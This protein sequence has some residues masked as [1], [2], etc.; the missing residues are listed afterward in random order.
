[1]CGGQSESSSNQ[2]HEQLMEEMKDLL[3]KSDAE[4]SYNSNDAIDNYQGGGYS[5]LNNDLRDGVELKGDSLA[6]YNGIMEN[7]EEIPEGTYYR[8]YGRT[9]GND[10]MKA[11]VGG[12][13][14]EH[15]FMSTSQ[16]KDIFNDKEFSHATSWKATINV[17]K[18][19]MGVD[20]NN[21]LGKRSS[22]P[23]EKEVIMKPS[24]SMR[25]NS[26]DKE[27]RTVN[28]TVL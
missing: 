22:F 12:I 19:N 2:T 3:D 14:T 26:Y 10:I 11:G 15:G 18:G 23:E 20:V 28:L 16:S 21:Y 27:S 24:R 1:M 9:I 25:V 4:D 7:M 13:V 17:P 8:G 5:Y 6:L